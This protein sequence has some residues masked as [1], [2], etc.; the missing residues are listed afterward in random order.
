MVKEKLMPFP[1][2]FQAAIDRAH[3]LA[4]RKRA[5][6]GHMAD[7][8]SILYGRGDPDI[9]ASIRRMWQLS[10]DEIQQVDPEL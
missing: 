4:A 7:V 6:L 1:F 2:P 5:I 9:D 10:Q 8:A 3:D